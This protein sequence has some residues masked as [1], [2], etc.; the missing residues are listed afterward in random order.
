MGNNGR[1][2]FVLV[3]FVTRL[4]GERESTLRLLSLVAGC[5]LVPLTY[6]LVRSWKCTLGASLFA[7][8]LVAVDGNNLFFASEA[9]P[10]ALVQLVAL[11]RLY[12]FSRLLLREQTT[13]VWI[14]WV[15]MGIFLF[16]LHCTTALIFLAEAL[17]YVV[18]RS[19]RTEV[20]LHWTYFAIGLAVV[21]V[22]S[23]P[24]WGLLQQISAR[25]DNWAMFIKRTGNPFKM[26]W[27]YPLGGYCWLSL[28]TLVLWNSFWRW[29]QP[30]G[31]ELE[32]TVEEDEDN[33]ES[34]GETLIAFVTAGF[35]LFAPILTV[36]ILTELDVARLFFRRY[37][38]ASSVS[39]APLTALILTRLTEKRGARVVMIACL[40]ISIGFVSPLPKLLYGG[41]P[42]SRSPED[43]RSAVQR[44][45]SEGPNDPVI[46]Y[47]GL[48]EADQW[49]DTSDE[50]ER[51]YCEFPLRGLYDVGVDRQIVSLPRTQPPKLTLAP[52]GSVAWLV[53]RGDHDRA[54]QTIAAVQAAMGAGWTTQDVPLVSNRVHVIRLS[55]ETE[56]DE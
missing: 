55:R 54:S 43:W 33:E 32:D 51:A 27:M 31:D 13:T 12:F 5:G 49:H 4:C 44:I 29:R 37:V 15:V 26:L 23:Y 18:L 21:V 30:V 6:V 34:R 42:F 3:Q 40:A 56:T 22:S 47:S 48:I 17:I 20:K 38:I 46:L 16:H 7:A 39:L 36:W 45:Q 35:W 41:N 11:C 1:L 14:Y 9:R 25:R 24:A 8:I 28:T 50:R 19:L 53:I 10:Y 2:Y 52:D